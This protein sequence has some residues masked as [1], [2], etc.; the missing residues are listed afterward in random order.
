MEQLGISKRERYKTLLGTGMTL[1]R[2]KAVAVAESARGNHLGASIIK[3]AKQV[4]DQCQYLT[5]YGAMPEARGLEAFY[6]R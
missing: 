4:Y 2:I 3:R 1:T 5:M 6:Q